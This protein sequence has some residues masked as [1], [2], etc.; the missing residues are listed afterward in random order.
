MIITIDKTGR[1][2]IPMPLRNRLGLTPGT[3]LEVDEVDGGVVLRPVSKVRVGIGGDG[4]PLLRAPEGTPKM[5]TDELLSV[6]DEVRAW[7]RS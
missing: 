1:V 5:T 6:L 7:P 3:E 4:L 2:V